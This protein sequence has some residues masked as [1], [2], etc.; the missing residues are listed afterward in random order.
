MAK[1]LMS[2][3]R[4]ISD[5]EKLIPHNMRYKW[6]EVVNENE[7][8]WVTQGI[9]TVEELKQFQKAVNDFF[10]ENIEKSYVT[11]RSISPSYNFKDDRNSEV[12]VTITAD[13]ILSAPYISAIWQKGLGEFLERN[14]CI[15]EANMVQY[16]QGKG[17]VNIW[18]DEIVPCLKDTETG[19]IKDTV[20]FRIESRSYLKKFRNS[21]GWHINWSEIPKD[22]EVYA[23]ALKDDNSIQGLVGIRNDKD[24]EAAYIYWACSAPHNNIHDFGSQKYVGVGGHLFAIASDKSNE[25]GYDSAVY[26]FAKNKQLLNHYVKVFNASPVCFLHKFHFV[27]GETQGHKLMEVYNYE[28]NGEKNS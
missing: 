16:K 9:F 6:F 23:L 19:E 15:T 22:V 28:W 14:G 24:A 18:I 12:L 3:L 5:F 4:S 13:K 25:W 26:G 2:M 1:S 7:L 17:C 11:S 10:G 20:V 8:Y 21:N 27:I